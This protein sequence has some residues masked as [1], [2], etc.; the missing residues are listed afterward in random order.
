MM[1]IASTLLFCDGH[2]PRQVKE[3]IAT[4]VSSLNRCPYCI[5]SHAFFLH[6]YGGSDALIDTLSTGNITQAPVQENE[7]ILLQFVHKV[8]CES[9]KA[10]TEDVSNLRDVGWNDQQIAEAVPIAALFACFNRVANAFGL[11]A[12][13]LLNVREK[14][15]PPENKK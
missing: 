2:L 7:R 10:S 5:D 12:Q 13:G 6:V 14:E 4:Y 8:T 9:Y 3:M 11:P 15:A 1:E